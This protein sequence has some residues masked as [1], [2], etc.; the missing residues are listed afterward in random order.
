MIKFK[1]TIFINY[2]L[3]V[4]CFIFVLQKYVIKHSYAILLENIFH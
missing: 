3:L 2:Y 4:M 1:Q